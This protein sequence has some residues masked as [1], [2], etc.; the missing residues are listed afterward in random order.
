MTKTEAVIRRKIEERANSIATQCNKTPIE[1]SA[2]CW[3]AHCYKYVDSYGEIKYI[4]TQDEFNKLKWA[5][6]LKDT[7]YQILYC[8]NHKIDA[9]IKAILEYA[10]TPDF[11]NF[12]ILHNLSVISPMWDDRKKEKP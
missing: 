8:S 9:K 5:A 10:L 4:L 3:D 2:S 7:A 12:E 6:A 11:P 1:R